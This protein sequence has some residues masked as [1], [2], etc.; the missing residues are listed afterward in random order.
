MNKL[1]SHLIAAVAALLALAAAP[2]AAQETT[3]YEFLNVTPSARVYGLGGHNITAIDDDITLVEQ[4]PALLGPEFDHQVGLNYMRYIGSTNFMGLRYGQ[5][6]SEHGAMAVGIQYYGY[7]SMTGTTEDGTITGDFNAHDLAVSATYSHDIYTNMR[8]GITLKYLS[9]SYES[10]S[11]AAITADLGFNFYNPDNELSL[12]VV[13]KNLGG[14]VKKFNDGRSANVPWDIQLGYS[15]MLGSS[16]LRLSLTAYNLRWWHLPYWEPEDK[17]N[18]NSELVK[19]DSFG[20]NFMR[21][22]VI[23]MEWL[24]SDNMW[25]AL[26]YNYKT[27]TDMS[28][29]QRSFL[30]GLSIGAGL[31]VK[32][33]GFSVAL[34][35]PHN[36]ATTF[37]VNLNTSIGEL[38]H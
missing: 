9:S 33:L 29:Y 19:K 13:A 36:G 21:H 7:G 34:A 15:Q 4:N 8:G 2:A 11:A 32:A 14:Q 37:M 17:N 27:R 22:L 25:L 31:K 26:G 30:S 20:R 38:L 6:V 23:G 18:Q 3:A 28:A 5:G 16:P 1:T 24:P 12:S 10:Y 35:Q